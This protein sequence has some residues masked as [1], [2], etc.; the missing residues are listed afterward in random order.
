MRHFKS[1]LTD[2]DSENSGTQL[3]LDFALAGNYISS[4]DQKDLLLKTEE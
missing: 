4:E 1:K 2:A 3:W